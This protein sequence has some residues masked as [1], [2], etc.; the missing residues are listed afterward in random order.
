MAS[1]GW[2]FFNAYAEAPIVT[3]QPPPEHEVQPHTSR[4]D[5]EA[6]T[7]RVRKL[8]PFK[9]VFAADPAPHRSS[10]AAT[11]VDE[12]GDSR[13]DVSP[14][15][16]MEAVDSRAEK[17]VMALNYPHFSICKSKARR[18]LVF[19]DSQLIYRPTRVSPL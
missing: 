16:D 3:A 14:Y 5:D 13:N 17:A 2:P 9:F 12:E 15:P 18:T 6:P 11:Q 19:S 1:F 7:A 10:H 4:V 8:S